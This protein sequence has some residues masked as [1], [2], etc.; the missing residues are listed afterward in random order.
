M[1][2]SLLIEEHQIDVDLKDL[3]K[4]LHTIGAVDIAYSKTDD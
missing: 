3:E 4:T 1:L 2:K